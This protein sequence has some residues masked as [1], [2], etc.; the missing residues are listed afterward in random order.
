MTE[1]HAADEPELR[2]KW[3]H[4][5]ENKG[6]DYAA[7]TDA[8]EVP[9]GR[10]YLIKQGPQQGRWFWSM[11]ASGP[12]ISRN[13]GDHSGKA[14][15]PREAARLVEDAWFAAIKGSSLEPNAYATA[16]AR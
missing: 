15:S 14:D 2:L 9:V 8:Y 13:S 6:P 3:R 1:A 12:E 11:T 4:T 16:K 5:W 10:I 7:H